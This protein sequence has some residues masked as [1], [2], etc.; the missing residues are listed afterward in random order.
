MN[1]VAFGSHPTSYPKSADLSRLF[2]VFRA[3]YPK[4]HGLSQTNRRFEPFPSEKARV[5]MTS[6]MFSDKSG[7][8][9]P[10]KPDRPYVFG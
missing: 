8:K 9:E 10:F 7:L 3:L 4:T 5:V 2:A 6:R 1:A